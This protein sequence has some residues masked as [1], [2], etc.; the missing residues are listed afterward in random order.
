MWD[1]KSF[2]IFFQL[3]VVPAGAWSLVLEA[4]F[5]KEFFTAAHVSGTE[6]PL[7]MDEII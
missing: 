4:Y 2:F 5:F 3:E 6:I 7:I 1:V